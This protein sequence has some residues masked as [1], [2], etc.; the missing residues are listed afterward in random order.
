MVGSKV[1]IM[2]S[3][4]NTTRHKVRAVIH[5]PDAQVVLV[6]TPGLHRPKT[7]LGERLNDTVAGSLRDVDAVLALVDATAAIGPGDRL[8]L[9]RAA[10]A[11]LASSDPGALF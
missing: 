9:G 3:R 6:D 4:P 8:V 7:A 2:S 10:D 1:S 5:R 11:V